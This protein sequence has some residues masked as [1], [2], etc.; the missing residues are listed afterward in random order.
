[1]APHPGRIVVGR[2]WIERRLPRT[3]GY[4]S[5][6]PRTV[7]T[8]IVKPQSDMIR[9]DQVHDVV[10]VIYEMVQARTPCCRMYERWVAIYSNDSIGPAEV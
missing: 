9:P 8:E 4:K 7:G 5:I 1:M 6:V 3:T 10:D 2:G